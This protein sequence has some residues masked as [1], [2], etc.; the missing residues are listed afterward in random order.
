MMRVLV[1]DDNSVNIYLLRALLEGSGCRVDEANNG[2]EALKLA[3]QQPPDLIITD[4]MM[5]VMDGYTLLR[6][7]KEDATLRLVPFVVYTAT[8]TQAAD[9]KL[10][11]DMGADAFI[12][13]PADP[14]VLIQRVNDVLRLR[15]RGELSVHAPT[16][17]QSDTLR[18]YSDV[19]FHKLEQRNAELE[20]RL[21]E[22][23][24]TEQAMRAQAD[25]LRRL[26]QHLIEVE[27]NERR[28]LARELHD[29]IGQNLTILNL[30]L[31]LVR[32][33][34]PPDA[35]ARVD[36]Q[37]TE[38]EQLLEATGGLVR[39]VM[40]DLRPPGL[41][42]LGLRAALASY[43]ARMQRRGNAAITICGAEFEPRLPLTV[44][45]TLFR[46]AQE[47]LVNA[48]KH[49]Q[50][51]HIQVDLGKLGDSATLT[52]TDNGRGFDAA[53]VRPVATAHLGVV[54]MRERIQ[55][56]GGSFHMVSEPGG[57]TRVVVAVPHAAG[58]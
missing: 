21:A 36:D 40:A 24:R 26:S 10:A 19:L 56:I 22:L 7:W 32:D 33:E 35:H 46:I 38:C 9:E 52:V 25:Q 5:P 53:A 29:R 3:R 18:G 49:A 31:S 48:F 20:Q 39:D 2:A 11:L 44:E 15:Q 28:R 57:G 47:A 41:D 8:Y 42:E 58:A 54:N 50:A 23:Q 51:T 27:E 14:G 30:S 13:K 37:L 55:S 1:V 34:L 6:H 17:S 4:L 12:V 43:A 16:G 45:L